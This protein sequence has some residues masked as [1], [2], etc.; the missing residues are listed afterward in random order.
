MEKGT[1]EILYSEAEESRGEKGLCVYFRKGII[2]DLVLYNS[3]KICLNK[4]SFLFYKMLKV[5]QNLLPV[6]CRYCPVAKYL[7]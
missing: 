7:P 3:E 2:L 4:V 1:Q 6:T 5:T